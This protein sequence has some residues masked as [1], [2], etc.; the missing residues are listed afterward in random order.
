MEASLVL[1]REVSND[2]EARFPGM[3]RIMSR[4]TAPGNAGCH[5][6]AG[7]PT[8]TVTTSMSWNCWWRT[9]DA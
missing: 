4:N 8:R 5:S 2:P 6:E 7:G 9:V 1:P 3:T